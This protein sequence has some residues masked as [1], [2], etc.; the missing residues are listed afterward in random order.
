MVALHASPL[1]RVN[2]NRYYRRNLRT[3]GISIMSKPVPGAKKYMAP[4]ARK[5]QI[6]DEA[7]RQAARLGLSKVTRVSVTTELGISAPMVNVH[8]GGIG[9]LH[10][11]LVEHALVRRNPEV[12]ADALAMGYEI[13]TADESLLKKARKLLDAA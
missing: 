11:V 10:T 1:D 2:F 4:E 12:V 7:W 9:G 8:F 13:E 6:F 5:Q 3:T